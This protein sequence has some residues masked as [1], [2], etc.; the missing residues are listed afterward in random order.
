AAW[1][2]SAYL[3]RELRLAKPFALLILLV[4]LGVYFLCRFA[5]QRGSMYSSSILTEGIAISCFLLFFRYLAE[6][7]FTRKKRSLFLC[8]LLTFLLI[9]TRKQML[10]CLI[11]LLVSIFFLHVQKRQPIKGL[12]TALSCTLCILAGST[13]LD[14]GYNYVLRG[15]FTR[16]SSDTRFITTVVFYTAAR[17]DSEYIEENSIKDLFLEIYD[18]CYDNEYLGDFAGKGWLARV[19]HFG[20]SYDCIQID[21]MW[22]LVNEFALDSGMSSDVVSLNQL[23]DQI[24]DSI[25]RSILP[26]SIRKII[27]VFTD[28]FLSGLITTVAQRNT[29]LIFYSI[30]IYL[31]YGFLLFIQIW[32]K[33]YKTAL[34]ASLTLLSIVLNVG[35]VSLVIFSQTRYTIYNMPLFYISLLIMLHETCIKKAE[36]I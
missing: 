26:H 3:Y 13:V 7:I 28:N 23:A 32:H 9:S 15:E 36:H 34:F 24:M 2:L 21:T 29:I 1:S 6:Y 31:V 19:S 16:H 14:L 5:A 20:D 18:I 12:L 22:P 35:V 4:P 30:L 8:S 33:N 17:D 11:L 27:R 25:N 10:I